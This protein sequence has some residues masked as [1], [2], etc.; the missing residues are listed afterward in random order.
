MPTRLLH[1]LNRLRK[2][3]I[4]E[5]EATLFN[6]LMAFSMFHR[7]IT[8][9]SQVRNLIQV[10]KDRFRILSNNLLIGMKTRL[11]KDSKMNRIMAITV[12]IMV[13]NLRNATTTRLHRPLHLTMLRLTA[14]VIMPRHIQRRKAEVI[15]AVAAE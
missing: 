1:R 3:I 15:L 13:T 14:Q 10:T 9:A 2:L 12:G 7:V 11:C 8:S 4:G 6:L 5:M